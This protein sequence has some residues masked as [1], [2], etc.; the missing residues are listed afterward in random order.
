MYEWSV[1]LGGTVIFDHSFA[2]AIFFAV[3]TPMIFAFVSMPFVCV[4]VR[5]F[6]VYARFN[7]DGH[8]HKKKNVYYVTRPSLY[9]LFYFRVYDI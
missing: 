6:A 5:L 3:S 9:T 8:C 1:N 4:C 2:F 7:A